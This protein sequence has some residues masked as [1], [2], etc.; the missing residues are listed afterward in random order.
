[1]TLLMAT[2]DRGLAARVV[3]D[4]LAVI[5]YG[6]GTGRYKRLVLQAQLEQTLAPLAARGWTLTWQ[7]V[8]R[9]LNQAADRLATLGVF[10]AEV[11]R[12]Q[13]HTQMRQHVVWHDHDAPPLPASFPVPGLADLRPDDVLESAAH[14]E[15]LARS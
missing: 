8:R 6:A 13:G 1:M 14:L 2:R 3:G 9:R 5:R 4:N 7:A 10:W 11:L 15:N 12:R